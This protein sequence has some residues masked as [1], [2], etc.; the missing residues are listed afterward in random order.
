M[1][2]IYLGIITERIPVIPMFIPTHIGG[3]VPPINFG[4]V[5][6]IPRLRKALRI[7]IIEWHEIK[8]LSAHERDEIGCWS[9]WQAVQER[10]PEPRNSFL[11]DL[12]TLGQLANINPPRGSCLKFPIL[13]ISYTKAPT[14]IKLLP[15]FEHDPHAS[16][17]SLASLAFPEIRADNLLPPMPSHNEH[18]VLPPDEQLLCYDYLY[19]VCGNQVRPDREG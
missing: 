19:Y 11:V 6:D 17:W 3:H 12:L 1:N 15:H 5:F 4:E 2:L 14:W 8:N 7:P 9:V 13:D 10:D 16:F 18:V